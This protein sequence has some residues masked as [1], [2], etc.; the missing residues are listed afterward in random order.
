MLADAANTHTGFIS[1]CLLPVPLTRLVSAWR[2]RTG[3]LVSR[4]QGLAHSR[5]LLR[6]EWGPLGS[7]TC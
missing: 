2:V 6:I 3:S 1:A 4:T 7:L 5:H